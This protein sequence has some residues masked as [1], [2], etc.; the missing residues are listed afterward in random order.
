MKDNVPQHRKDRN[1]SQKCTAYVLFVARTLN[2]EVV[3]RSWLCFCP[4]QT[5]VKCFTYR[6][7]RAD[8]TKC[9]S[10]LEIESSTGSTFL[11]A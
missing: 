5:C 2:G 8:T 9:A 1:V 4:S 6:L 11:S 7:M 10:L 3:D